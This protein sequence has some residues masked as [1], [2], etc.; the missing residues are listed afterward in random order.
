MQSKMVTYA[1]VYNALQNDSNIPKNWQNAYINTSTELFSKQSVTLA[2][3]CISIPKD[4]EFSKAFYKAINQGYQSTLTKL[5][6]SIKWRCQINILD[7][8]HLADHIVTYYSD[9]FLTGSQADVT[10]GLENLS[11]LDGNKDR[12][13]SLVDAL[14]FISI[15]LSPNFKSLADFENALLPY[16]EQTQ[17][18]KE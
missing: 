4:T 18:K 10:A 7:P 9:N 12:F 5:T 11:F 13:I 6:L 17:A 16:L 15:N 2:T 1:Y 14:G 8:I 3:L